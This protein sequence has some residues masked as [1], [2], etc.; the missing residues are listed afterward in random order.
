MLV[1]QKNCVRTKRIIT[2]VIRLEQL[3]R[4]GEEAVVQSGS[5]KMVF[6]EILQN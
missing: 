4:G 2:L 5:L 6:L 3:N 1:F